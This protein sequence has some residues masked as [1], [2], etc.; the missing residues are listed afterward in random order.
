[1]LQRGQGGYNHHSMQLRVKLRKSLCVFF[2]MI[3]RPMMRVKTILSV[4]SFAL[5]LA[6]T[7]AFAA[8]PPYDERKA[9]VIAV[10]DGDTINVLISEFYETARAIHR[11]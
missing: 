5:S 9:R 11:D 8:P 6:L 7:P 10:V 4:L 1:M 2:D 3:L